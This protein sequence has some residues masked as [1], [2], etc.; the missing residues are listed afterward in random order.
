MY[1][2][3]VQIDVKAR[4]GSQIVVFRRTEAPFPGDKLGPYQIVAFFRILRRRGGKR[5]SSIFWRED[6][7]PPTDY[8]EAGRRTRMTLLNTSAT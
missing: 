8:F 6:F 2:E 4:Q 1:G 7:Q 5:S 3:T